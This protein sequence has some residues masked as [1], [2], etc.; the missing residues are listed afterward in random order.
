[1]SAA[2][3][4]KRPSHCD[5]LANDKSPRAVDENGNIKL[6]PDGSGE[7]M[8][9]DVYLR[10]EFPPPGKARAPRPGATPDDLLH[11]AIGTLTNAMDQLEQAYS[12][13][14]QV[15]GNDGRALVEDRGVDTQLCTAWRETLT[16][17]ND[18]LGYW[19][20]RFKQA[21]GLKTDAARTKPTDDTE[22]DVDADEDWD[23][24]EAPSRPAAPLQ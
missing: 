5:V 3:T 17:I 16:G 18:D 11:N 7:L 23:E 4:P 9:N 12:A 14:G 15:L 19:S 22:Q 21:N 13:I 2:R 6:L 1:M 20:R 24:P 10:G 8:I